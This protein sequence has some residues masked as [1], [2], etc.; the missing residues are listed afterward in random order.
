MKTETE[1]MFR[2]IPMDQN[3]PL[4]SNFSL[5]LAVDA[6]KANALAHM[7]AAVTEDP[8][9]PERLLASISFHI[10]SRELA[11]TLVNSILEEIDKTYFDGYLDEP[12]GDGE[13]EDE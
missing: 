12:E 6:L 7:V 9:N 3:S 11:V 1:P 10:P 13:E 5:V 4:N 2:E 8:K